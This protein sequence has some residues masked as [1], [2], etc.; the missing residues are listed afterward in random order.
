MLAALTVVG[1]ITAALVVVLSRVGERQSPSGLEPPRVT[2]DAPATTPTWL[3]RLASIKAREVT[4]SAPTTGVIEKH[5][6]AYEVELHGDFTWLACDPCAKRGPLPVTIR[7]SIFFRVDPEFRRVV[8][9]NG[10][11]SLYAIGGTN[12]VAAPH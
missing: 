4:N 10:P 5:R 8:L 1:G 12:G 3:L 11:R 2:I 9:T 6:L 7:D